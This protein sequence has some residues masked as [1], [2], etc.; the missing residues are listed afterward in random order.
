MQIQCPRCGQFHDV[1][2]DAAHTPDAYPCCSPLPDT[3]VPPPGSASLT[4]EAEPPFAAENE[5]EERHRTNEEALTSNPS[6]SIPWEERRGF[7]DLQAYWKTTQG[8]LFHPSQ[9]FAQWN[10]PREMEGALIFLVI[11]GSLGQILAHYW[12]MFLQSAMGSLVIVGEDWLGFGLFALK[13]P[14]LVL[15]SG[16]VSAAVIHFFLFLLRATS[17]TWSK[18]FGFY[19]YLGGALACLQLIPIAGIFI[20]P[21]WG[22]VSSVC[23]LREM[24]HTT[25]W[26]VVAAFLLPLAIIL[27]LLFFLAM[28]IVGAGLV[29]LNSLLGL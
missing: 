18:T 6:I 9:S 19:A 29:A 12:L 15:F 26:R 17:Q 5:A 8:I 4:A 23:G 13:A 14:F 28:L 22:L 24:H 27:I 2:G 1:D 10:P 25:I 20:A 16:L 7:L 3:A 21:I 11:F